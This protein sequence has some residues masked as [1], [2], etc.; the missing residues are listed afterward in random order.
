MGWTI[1]EKGG[2]PTREQGDVFADF[3]GEEGLRGGFSDIQGRKWWLAASFE[4]PTTTKEFDNRIG[5]SGRSG[6]AGE[7][8]RAGCDEGTGHTALQ[9]LVKRG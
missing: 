8:P 6:S 1:S 7:M 4:V 9:G 3:L 2:G 5:R